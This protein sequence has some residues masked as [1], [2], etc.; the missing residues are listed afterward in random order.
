MSASLTT[1]QHQSMHCLALVVLRQVLESLGPFSRRTVMR[2]G[3][4]VA[5]RALLT[6]P[7][8][9]DDRPR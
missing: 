6:A 7:I 9:R 2:A 8:M 1:E 5:E 4:L 3:V